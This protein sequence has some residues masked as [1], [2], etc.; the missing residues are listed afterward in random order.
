MS[1]RLIFD[2][3]K[4]NVT[5]GCVKRKMFDRIKNGQL[6]ICENDVGV[7]VHY[8]NKKIVDSVVFHLS[9]SIEF[10]LQNAIVVEYGN[11]LNTAYLQVFSKEHTKGRCIQGILLF[12]SC[13]MHSRRTGIARHAK[14][15]VFAAVTQEKPQFI[16]VRLDNF[17]N[18]CP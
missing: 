5:A 14:A 11:T 8:L 7:A 4:H 6:F 12:C 2:S 9:A 15:E 10:Y 3:A 13:Y 17:V 18:S 16:R 1:N